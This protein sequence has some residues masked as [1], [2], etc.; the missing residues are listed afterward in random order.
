M[1]ASG[2]NEPPQGVV[3]ISA[4]ELVVRLGRI[5]QGS[6]PNDEVVVVQQ[7]QQEQQ[8]KT[9]SLQE[10]PSQPQQQ[11]LPNI[12]CCDACTETNSQ[13]ER[14]GS[15]DTDAILT[16]PSNSSAP[17][18]SH[19]KSWIHAA[20][21]DSPTSKPSVSMPGSPALSAT[22]INCAA[23]SYPLLPFVAHSHEP[24]LLIDTRP[25]HMFQGCHDSSM[26]RNLCTGHLKGAINVQIPTLLLRRSQRALGASP[27]LLDSIDIASYIHTDA[28]KQRFRMVCHSQ[29]ASAP[30]GVEPSTITELV[31]ALWFI[32]V[33]V[34]YEDDKSAFAGHLFLRILSAIRARAAAHAEP[35][36]ASLRRGLYFVRGGMRQLREEAAYAAYFEVGD[37]PA[38][39]GNDNGNGRDIDSGSTVSGSCADKHGGSANVQDVAPDSLRLGTPAIDASMLTKQM[40]T[41]DLSAPPP[42]RPALP[43]IDT[44]IQHVPDTVDPPWRN[45]GI[46]VPLRLPLTASLHVSTDYKGPLMDEPQTAHIISEL[47]EFEVSTIVPGEVYLGSGVQKPSDME[48]LEQL[49]IKAVLN[50]AAEVPYLH[51]ASPLRHHPHIVEYKHI[52]MRDVV[53]AV[54]VQ[55]HLEEACCF[56]EQMCSRSLPTFV[57]CRAGKSRSA[58]CVIAYLIKTRRWSF[59]QAYAFVA[60]RRPR[61]S[62]NIGFI[63]ELMH[64]ERVVL[65]TGPAMSSCLPLSPR[66]SLPCPPESLADGPTHLRDA[67]SPWRTRSPPVQ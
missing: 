50:T 8:H 38:A 63:A 2:T 12:G 39:P 9:Q 10:L 66:K 11:Q 47:S 13:N 62:P 6:G 57:H 17:K 42:R 23:E 22:R 55:Q 64:F 44:T 3:A 37:V 67:V 34:L 51:D 65:G 5:L 56:L 21:S 30:S 61:T 33:V 14:Q 54:G 16:H 46:D 20:P 48:K 45:S 29:L 27:A 19:E 18:S 40:G 24:M 7:Q 41:F 35:H 53:E 32:D 26:D 60:A 28:D 58:T 49:G 43:R 31:R 25:A 59:K 52:P 1:N 4:D 15:W 36:L